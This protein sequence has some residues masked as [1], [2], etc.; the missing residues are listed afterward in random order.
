METPFNQL[1]PPLPPNVGSP[2]W[3]SGLQSFWLYWKLDPK[4]AAKYVPQLPGDQKLEVAIFD[5]DD[6]EASLVSLD[7][8]RYL[9]GGDSWLE[10]TQEVEF[11]LYVYP[12]SREP[13]V[14]QLTW[15]QFL[16]GWDQTKSLGGWRLHVPCDDQIAIDAGKGLFGEPKY[17]AQFTTKV[18]HINSPDTKTW[19]YEV[20][21]PGKP[22]PQPS[23]LMWSLFA[24]LSDR[25]PEHY[26]ASPLIEYGVLIKD[27]SR[28]VVANEW[29]FYGPFDTYWLDAKP[30]KV[31]LAGGPA[32]LRDTVKDLKA[33][34]GNRA[35]IAAQV[36]NSPP[37][38]VESRGWY[39]VPN[40]QTR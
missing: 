10:T 26:D 16:M 33:L 19:E 20:Y 12:K 34:I 11:N 39:Q 24:D 32:D 17:L 13:L 4:L 2:F 9:S 37:V 30:A 6:D 22:P 21:V 15:K 8:Q 23:E 18:P 3:Y 29:N 36:F 28:H 14:P 40:T 35:P 25:V 38:S 31:N 1:F 27:G 7:L 5:F